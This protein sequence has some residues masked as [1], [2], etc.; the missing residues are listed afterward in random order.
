MDIPSQ[1]RCCMNCWTKTARSK[2]S[3][4]QSRTLLSGSFT[5]ILP[6]RN[7]HGKCLSEDYRL[8]STKVSKI[9]LR[10]VPQGVFLLWLGSLIPSP[11]ILLACFSGLNGFAFNP[12][13]LLNTVFYLLFDLAVN[14]HEGVCSLHNR[15]VYCGVYQII[16]TMCPYAIWIFHVYARNYGARV[17]NYSIVDLNSKISLP[18]LS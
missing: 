8:I 17:S 16:A 1:K 9:S 6:V 12:Q 15:T 11:A 10:Y 5:M 13:F 3:I 2:F 14:E 18:G 7:T 4:P